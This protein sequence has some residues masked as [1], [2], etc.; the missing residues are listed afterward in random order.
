MGP[1]G[2]LVQE[3]VRGRF[4]EDA[5]QGVVRVPGTPGLRWG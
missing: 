2:R 3:E 4:V 1:E 5:V